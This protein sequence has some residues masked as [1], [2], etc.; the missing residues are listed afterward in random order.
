[1]ANEWYVRIGE[2]EYGP[3]ASAKLKQLADAG[4]ISPETLVRLGT[5]GKWVP[6]SKV[7][8]LFESAPTQPS[9][10][11]PPPDAP[12]PAIAPSPPP[13]PIVPPI[14]TASIVEP[15]RSAPSQSVAVQV[16]VSQS[17]AAHS[18]GIASLV[19]G[20]L[21][22]L[23][24]CLPF[25]AIP[26]TALGLAL[27]IGGLFLAFARRGSGIGFSIAGS[28]VCALVLL[29]CVL[30]TFAVGTAISEGAKAID[31]AGKKI[32]AASKTNQ[33][34]A[35]NAD[36]GEPAK[37]AN[38]DEI[39]WADAA[40]PVQQGDIRVSVTGVSV[41]R[42]P[43]LALGSEKTSSDQL[44]MIRLRIENVGTTRKVE[45]KSWSGGASILPDAVAALTDNLD[46]TYKRINFG[47]GT[48][49]V[50]QITSESVYPEKAIDDVLVF[51]PPISAAEFLKLELPAAAFGGTGQLRLKIPK[52]MISTIAAQ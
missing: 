31:E 27:G 52:S 33:V 7:K 1:M 22:L 47:F 14:L 48:Q 10:S 35:E 15:P 26:L 17:R 16:N 45:Y 50:G 20:I 32:E 42:V 23:T 4:K 5:D 25:I 8:G 43:L 36:G 37:L 41:N 34:V 30:F 6:A 11:L 24:F 12:Q 3:F 40:K 21:G 29:P 9:A 39:E 2:K 46:N 51:E 44:I 28:A 38:K 18:L 19:L 13:P 49:V